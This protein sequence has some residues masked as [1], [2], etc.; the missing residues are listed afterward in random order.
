LARYCPEC[1]L[2]NRDTAKYCNDCG[3]DLWNRGTQKI[4]LLDNRYKV[5]STIKSGN[6]GCVYKAVDTRLDIKVAV[7]KML[8]AAGSSEDEK[9]AKKRFFEE[10]KILSKLHHG[11]LP[12]VS[13]FFIEMDPKSGKPAHYL[14]MTFIEG[15]DLEAIMKDRKN[16]PLPVDESL[17]YFNQILN[18]L[19][20]LHCHKPPVIY[21]DMKPSNIMLQDGTVF[22]VD[23]GIARLFTPQL[24]GTLIGT[25]GYA[26]PEQYK[27]FADQRSDLYSLGAMMHYLLTGVD[28]QNSS[29]PPFKFESLRSLNPAVPDYLN[30]I[31]LSML[32]LFA[33][34]RPESADRI[35]NMLD[36]GEKT[37]K[38][39]INTII[40]FQ[41]DSR[42]KNPSMILKPKVEIIKKGSYPPYGGTPVT[43]TPRQATSI[44]I[45]PS[46]S[47]A[48]VKAAV[49]IPAGNEDEKY[50]NIYEAIE[51]NDMQAVKDFI[52]KKPKI[53]NF[54]DNF[55]WTP[56]H[57]AVYGEHTDI[58]KLL[59]DYGADVNTKYKDGTTP[60]HLAALRGQTDAIKLLIDHDADV[61][62]MAN[63]G[64]TSLSL[65]T[66]QGYTETANLL[67]KHG[68]KE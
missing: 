4:I 51:N 68:A 33:D 64:F 17:D 6:M 11:G 60:L 67:R 42:Q 38:K 57:E 36:A 28:P 22:L 46:P 45:T 25:P 48:V 7:K 49:A 43:I 14:V 16:K 53:V 37:D 35:L 39:V 54:R 32:D 21:R 58:A 27:G 1:G 3:A 23:F 47:P 63:G 56:L 44:V 13:D 59:I 9:Y 12:K 31:I 20:Y 26:S 30:N 52:R 40:P 50:K 61:N 10:A 66:E 55:G 65:A 29:L 62:A 19:N 24:K 15:R 5:V 18:I 8:H 2:E 41:M 34:N